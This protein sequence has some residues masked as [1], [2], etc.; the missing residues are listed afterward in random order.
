MAFSKGHKNH[1][2]EKQAFKY[3]GLERHRSSE[4]ENPK[5]KKG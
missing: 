3:P 4:Q 5:A 2:L 1:F